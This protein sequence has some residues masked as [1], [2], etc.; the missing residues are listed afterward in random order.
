FE[1]K[2]SAERVVMTVGAGGALNVALKSIVNP[3]DE[4]IIL[5]PYF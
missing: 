3:G 5:A 4:V 2:F 1:A